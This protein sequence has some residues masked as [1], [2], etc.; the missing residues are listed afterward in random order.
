MPG[1][2]LQEDEDVA[3]LPPNLP[4][5]KQTVSTQGVFMYN[6]GDYIILLVM[7]GADSQVLTDLFDTQ[8]WEQIESQG[9]PQLETSHNIR[10]NNMIAELRR[11]SSDK[12]GIYQPLLIR[13]P[14]KKGPF[15]DLVM[16][17]LKQDSSEWNYFS[18]LDGFHR[19]VQMKGK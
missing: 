3:I 5:N 14:M 1:D 17:C 6:T 7:E 13:T 18:F 9:L 4:L 12:N 15:N 8:D 11:R 2:F 16:S 19:A 10:V